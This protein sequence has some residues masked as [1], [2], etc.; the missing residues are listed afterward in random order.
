MLTNYG[1]MFVFID[2]L[3]LLKVAQLKAELKIRIAHLNGP[4]KS[5]K[6]DLVAQLKD[7]LVRGTC[8]IR[9]SKTR[10]RVVCKSDEFKVP[11]EGPPPLDRLVACCTPPNH[12][13]TI[14]DVL[15]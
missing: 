7:V 15:D 3:A 12:L 2:P 11:I 9:G 10:W 4:I 8:L 13:T 14:S 1:I 5:A 6:K